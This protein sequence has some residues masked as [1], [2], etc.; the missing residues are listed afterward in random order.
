M[1]YGH[2]QVSEEFDPQEYFGFVYR[3]TNTTNNMQYIGCKMLHKT[4]KR[5]PLKG[6]KNKR[7]VK[8]DSDWRKYTGSS[9]R[10]NEDIEL[11]GKDKFKFEIIKLADCR[12]EL[13]YKEYKTI[14]LEDAI[15]NTGYY[16][17]Y[18]G[19]VGQCPN[20]KRI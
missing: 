6:K 20:N 8:R 5:P 13:G 11:L 14:I 10:L 9:A 18:L 16:N 12:W 15:P 17:E 3:I 4:I 19:K 7:H 2:W 1:D